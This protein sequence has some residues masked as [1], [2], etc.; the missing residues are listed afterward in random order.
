MA[1]SAAAT[2]PAAPDEG[3]DGTGGNDVALA[4]IPLGKDGLPLFK[5]EEEEDE[6]SDEDDLWDLDGEMTADQIT[7]ALAEEK[8]RK[9]VRRSTIRKIVA[10]V[11]RR[12]AL[13]HGCLQKAS[14]QAPALFGSQPVFSSHFLALLRRSKNVVD[15]RSRFI[16]V[17][18]QWAMGLLTQHGKPHLKAKLSSGQNTKKGPVPCRVRTK[19]IRS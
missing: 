8:R 6:D 3:H 1:S 7:A 17:V 2:T 16:R 10:C 12:R 19:D 5:E 11:T 4:T 9:K 14:G 13:G 15:S 18:L